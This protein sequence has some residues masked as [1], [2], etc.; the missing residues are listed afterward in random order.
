[1]TPKRL[2]GPYASP[3]SVIKQ[4][5]RAIQEFEDASKKARQSTTWHTLSASQSYIASIYS[6]LAIEFLPRLAVSTKE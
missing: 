1:M 4:P 5:L 2:F 3:D 6:G